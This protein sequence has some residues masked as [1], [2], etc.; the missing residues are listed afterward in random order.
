M[1]NNQTALPTAQAAM[2]EWLNR[3]D[4]DPSA[5]AVQPG[6][7]VR[8]DAWT[9]ITNKV[10]RVPFG[11]DERSRLVRAHEMMHAKVSPAIM[12]S[13]YQ[14]VWNVSD[15]VLRAAEEFRVNMLV[16]EAGFDVDEL[17]DGSESQTGK[18]IGKH[19]DWN[20]AVTFIG[21]TA[22]T[23]AS[24]DFR[25]GL[26]TSNPEMEKRIAIIEKGLKKMWKKHLKDNTTKA[27][28][29]TQPKQI[30]V[31]NEP[32]EAIDSTV[33]FA[34]F[35]KQYAEYL[36]R[37]IVRP[38][39]GVD[40][41]G[42]M[43]S[44]D[45]VAAQAKGGASGTFAVLLEKQ[46]PKPTKVDGRIGRKRLPANVGRNP[47]RINRML[48]DPEKRV[49][50][51]RAKGQGGIVLI[52][53]SGSMSLT[54]DDIWAIIKAAPGCVIIGYSHRPGST[55][56]PNVWT[57][58]DRGSVAAEIPVGNGGN[59]VDGPAI[60]FAQKKRRNGEPFIWVCDGVVTDG[61]NDRAVPSLERECA[62]LVAR[63]GIHMVQNVSEAVAALQA[64][65]SGRRLP[66]KAVGRVAHHR[67]GN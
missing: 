23:K 2:P 9:N 24:A 64:A 39:E 13:R 31:N 61:A 19:N 12:D 63:H 4:A 5:W 59:G 15:D 1:S 21:A 27:I 50:D 6:Q 10:M 51:K 52:D 36:E 22:G 54:D 42:E 66:T 55:T 46:V 48:I 16:K 67:V 3:D 38:G 45:E 26:K 62:T 29:S 11:V 33:G 41:D 49:F 53:Q 35:T 20:N 32:P 56:I 65:S 40:G 18:T 58:A 17:A 8:G 47:R 34:I 25:R 28:A 44:E 60:R 30:V 7:P 14:G 37:F 57:I 43:P